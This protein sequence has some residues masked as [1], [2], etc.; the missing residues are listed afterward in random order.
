MFRER[1]IQGWVE[2]VILFR[3]NIHLYQLSTETM[4]V[5][6]ISFC[7]CLLELEELFQSRKSKREK[8]SMMVEE[9]ARII[10][11]HMFMYFSQI[12][13]SSF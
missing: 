13:G 9:L 5:T 6:Q 4:F 7:F 11:L 1:E 8:K 10:S 12:F 3:G 2:I